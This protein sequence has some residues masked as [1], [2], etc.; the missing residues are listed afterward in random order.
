MLDI[1]L[2]RENPEKVKKAA[3][4]RG[5]QVNI[6]ELLRLD[7]E[8]RELIQKIDELKSSQNKSGK[9]ITRLSGEAKE[10][11]L[12]RMKGIKKDLK[13][14]EERLKQVEEAFNI[15]MRDLP[16]IPLEDVPIGK[17]ETGSRVVHEWGDKPKFDFNG[18]DHVAL[19]ELLDI[20]DVERAAKVSGS[21]FAYLK[22]RAVLMQF[23]LINYGLS[24]LIKQGFAPMIPPI[25]VKDEVMEAM[26][27]LEHGGNLETYHFEK[28]KLYF[29]GTSEQSGVPYYMNEILD[30]K[31][32]PKRY[33]CYTTC[34]RRE[35]G[36]YGKDVRGILRLH[37]FDKLE[38][39]SIT[40]P[41]KS[42]QEHDFILSMQEKLMQG[43]RLPYRVMNLCTGDLGAPSAKTYDIETWMPSQ[44]KYRET[45][46][47][48]NCT[49]FQA[50]R[51]NMRYKNKQGKNEFC[52][53]LNGTAFAMGRTLV[54]I[55]ENYQ[56]KDGSIE[57]PRLLRPYMNKLKKITANR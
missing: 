53:T 34:F 24:F 47:A 50:R 21:R 49:D 23:A 48:S 8:R 31:D 45:H 32:L 16:N 33:L 51:L 36:S 46:S 41:D 15:I 3:E 12:D 19:G 6:D 55:L 44:G 52:H 17:D 37:Q 2:I 28:D 56:Q 7:H 54:A 57:V 26:G 11:I 35:A 14:F 22:N 9:D 18:K 30:E 25:M 13:D 27:Y 1:K 10:K 5:E 29:V 39:I 40:T 43:L 42:R 20:I 4:S 38:M